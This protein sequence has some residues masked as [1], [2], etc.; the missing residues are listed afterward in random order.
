MAGSQSLKVYKQLRELAAKAARAPVGLARGGAGVASVVDGLAG[1]G[2]VARAQVG[3]ATFVL[4]GVARH[5]VHDA[6]EALL[7]VESSVRA[8]MGELRTL[9]GDDQA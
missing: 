9:L 6:T 8:A 1:G 7:A 4:L 5:A 3:W 2:W